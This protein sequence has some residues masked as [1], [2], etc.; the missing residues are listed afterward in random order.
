M[1]ISL[2]IALLL[3]ASSL[4]VVV[5]VQGEFSQL[6]R[7]EVLQAEAAGFFQYFETEGRNT[8]RYY[9][10]RQKIYFYSQGDRYEYRQV[11]TSIVRQKNGS[12]YVTVCFHVKEFSLQ[13]EGNGVNISLVLE[14]H[15]VAWQVRNAIFPAV[16]SL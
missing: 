12:G 2:S 3:L 5:W 4:Q 14:D 16:S 6:K 11:G 10:S 15:G 7:K 13:R 8:D 1:V 9:L